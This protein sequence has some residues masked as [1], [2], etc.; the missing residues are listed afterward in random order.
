MNHYQCIIIDDEQDAI[1]LLS[2]RIEELFENIEIVA[3]VSNWKSALHTL[4]S[5]PADIVFLD[6]SMPEK[7]GFDLLKLLPD[8]KTEIIFVTAHDNFALNAFAVS[9]TGYVLKPIDDTEL[10]AAINTALRR[11]DDKRAARQGAT[12]NYAATMNVSPKIR[13]PNN[14]NFDYVNIQDIIYLESVNKCTMIVTDKGK[15]TSATNLGSY[16][17]LTDEFSFFQVHRSFIVNIN[18]VMRYESSGLLIMKDKTEI[19]I[20]RNLKQDFLQLLGGK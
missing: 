15:Y 8:L 10:S 13:I 9:A 14:S 4:R 19:P 11:I 12:N 20:S 17:Y 3:T 2:N 7:S 5:K 6:I 1:E 18:Y 16:K